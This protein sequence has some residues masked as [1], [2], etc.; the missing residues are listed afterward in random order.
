M[1]PLRRGMCIDVPADRSA[2]GTSAAPSNVFLQSLALPLAG[3]GPCE[4][5]EITV[6]TNISSHVCIGI[7]CSFSPSAAQKSKFPKL[8]FLIS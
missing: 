2:V 3:Q 7:L 4:R 8:V 1:D 6:S 5:C